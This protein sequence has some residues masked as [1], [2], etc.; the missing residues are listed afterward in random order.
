MKKFLLVL[1][2]TALLGSFAFAEITGV[3]APTV[4]GYV[5]SS[6]GYDMDYEASGFY[7]TSS[8][9]LTLP[10]LDGSAV[11]GGSD[12]YY[13]EITVDGIGWSLTNDGF[14]D[15][16]ED[17]Y[18]GDDPWYSFTDADEDGI[19]D[20]IDPDTAGT[21][22]DT[23]AESEFES[24]MD[25]SI[26]A[27]LVLDKFFVKLGT[28]GFV[29]NNV[30]YTATGRYTLDANLFKQSTADDEYTQ[31][32]SFGYAT[33]L[34]SVELKIANKNDGWKGDKDDNTG[35]DSDSVTDFFDNDTDTDSADDNFTANTANEYAFGAAVTITPMEG[36]SIP[37]TFFY[38]GE[39]GAANRVLMGAGANPT[40]KLGS[41]SL[42][43]PVDYVS[44]GNKYGFEAGPT[45]TYNLIEGGTNIALMGLYGM[46]DETQAT[47][48]SA[49]FKVTL[50]ETET[51]GFVENLT[52]TV[53]FEMRDA[54]NYADTDGRDN[55][56]TVDGDFFYNIGGLKPYVNFGYGYDGILDA[57]AGVIL[58]DSFTGL[59]N[60][61]ITADYRNR[62]LT[63][64][65]YD[66]TSTETEKGRFT[67]EAKVSF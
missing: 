22:V 27:K 55:Y 39:Y 26:S 8:L 59:D 19:P 65:Q 49:G 13:G 54:L 2:A 10:L 5:T 32:A 24:I 25:A 23:A 64:G 63:E 38:D 6:Y 58:L 31:G 43:V 4:S 1:L 60:T 9:K 57:G 61:T 21:Q 41:L 7:N 44:Y 67:I 46:Y 51:K 18:V 14:Y 16:D 56:W 66:G 28:P 15:A 34:F 42:A 40:F 3:G 37:V 20:D 11:K 33:D 62:R 12:K 30:D 36:L 45:V 48:A 35:G 53:V 47:N 52:A 17:D 50:S 29:M